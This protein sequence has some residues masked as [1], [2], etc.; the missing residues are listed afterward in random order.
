MTGHG[1]TGIARSA[2]LVVHAQ[3]GVRDYVAQQDNLHVV[4]GIGQG[5]VAGAEQAEYVV[6]EEQPKD[7]QCQTDNQVQGQHN[8]V[9]L[10]KQ[11]LT[12]II[13][14]LLLKKKKEKL[15]KALPI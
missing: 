7:G 5:V 1:Q 13:G 10:G 3:E 8:K 12:T 9:I 6:D 11:K 15:E 2:H 4:A 14:L